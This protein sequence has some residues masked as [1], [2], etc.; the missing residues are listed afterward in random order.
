MYRFIHTLG[1]LP[2]PLYSGLNPPG[3]QAPG[4]AEEEEEEGKFRWVDTWQKPKERCEWAEPS[5]D[6]VRGTLAGPGEGQA[7]ENQELGRMPEQQPQ[8]PAYL[9][10][11]R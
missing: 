5:A 7:G 9:R 11:P 1:G 3:G 10:D 6:G 8:Q 4:P 2:G